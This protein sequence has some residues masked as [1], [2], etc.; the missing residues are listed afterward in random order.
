MHKLLLTLLFTLLGQS[1][2]AQ[3][4]EEIDDALSL[5]ELIDFGDIDPT[6]FV[7]WNFDD[8]MDED[9][10]TE[11]FGPDALI[12]F[13]KDFDLGELAELEMGLKWK[14]FVNKKKKKRKFLES[15]TAKWIFNFLLS[16]QLANYLKKA[17]ALFNLVADNDKKNHEKYFEGMKII[18]LGVQNTEEFSVFMESLEGSLHRINQIKNLIA[19]N[20]DLFTEQEHLFF[21][22]S[23]ANVVATKSDYLTDFENVSTEGVLQMEDGQRLMVI[24]HLNQV[25][26]GVDEGLYNLAALIEQIVRQRGGGRGGG[27]AI[28]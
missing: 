17:H 24:S 3:T 21:T 4:D 15:S 27:G 6:D 13:Y 7:K 5:D 26:E 18:V 11:L 10:I 19:K 14:D 25:A 2:F 9:Q 1:L 16:E 20:H 23:L 12:E 22:E 28:R 8:Y